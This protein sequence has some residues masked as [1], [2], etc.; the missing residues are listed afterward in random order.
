MASYNDEQNRENPYRIF[1]SVLFLVPAGYNEADKPVRAWPIGVAVASLLCDY[2][3]FY[4]FKKAFFI[5]WYLQEL[6]F[7]PEQQLM[8]VDRGDENSSRFGK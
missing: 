5:I 3:F 2:F 7:A 1:K 8:A 6:S 4:F